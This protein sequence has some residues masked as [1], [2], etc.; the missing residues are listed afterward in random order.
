MEDH[1]RKLKVYDKKEKI[2]GWLA[3]VPRAQSEVLDVDIRKY[4]NDEVN[5]GFTQEQA[6]SEAERCMRCY[7]IAMVAN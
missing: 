7:Y 4:N 2:T 3:G 1:L 5:F 6:I